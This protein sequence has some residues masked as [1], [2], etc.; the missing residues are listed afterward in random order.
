MILLKRLDGIA[1]ELRPS[2]LDDMGLGAAIE[3]QLTDFGK[4]TGML[5]SLDYPKEE[6]ILT[7]DIKTGLF[8]IVQESLTNVG[9]YANAKEV[10]VV[11]KNIT[12]SLQLTVTDNGI[13]FDKAGISSRKTLGILG[14]R[15]RSA[16]MNGT[17]EI[18]STPGVGT[19]VF[20]TIPY[21][22]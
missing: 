15:E 8:R 21:Y 1:Y 10:S 9:R 12:G 16:M 20:V 11:V 13:G 17:Y 3:W 18:E 5:T 6:L 14:M 2:L 7:D 4:R 19:N 22:A